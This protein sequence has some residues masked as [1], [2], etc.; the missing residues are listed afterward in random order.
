MLTR[1]WKSLNKNIYVKY[2]TTLGR[3]REWA[4]FKLINPYPVVVT[5]L[6]FVG[7]TWLTFNE[8]HDLANNHVHDGWPSSSAMSTHGNDMI[9]L[10]G[11]MGD[12]CHGCANG[13]P[14]GKWDIV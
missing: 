3:G 12:Q 8:P 1:M 13:W 14:D 4:L 6:D 10:A 5:Y 7:S 11:S 2:L 9:F